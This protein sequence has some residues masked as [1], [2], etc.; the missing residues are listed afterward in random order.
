MENVII[1]VNSNTIKLNHVNKIAQS[2]NKVEKGDYRH[3][4]MI[5]TLSSNMKGL[6]FKSLLFK[7]K[8]KKKKN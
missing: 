3:S 8:K 6:A 2:N 4:L 7:L 1:K 5:T